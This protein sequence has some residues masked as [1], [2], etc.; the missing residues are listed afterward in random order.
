MEPQLQYSVLI[1]GIYI[2]IYCYVTFGY[3]Y[4]E[5]FAISTSDAQKLDDYQKSQGNIISIINIYN[6]INLIRTNF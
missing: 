6:K 5:R 3:N 4:V 2:S 1:I